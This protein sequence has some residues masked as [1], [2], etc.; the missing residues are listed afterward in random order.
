MWSS[1]ELQ[2]NIVQKLLNK[3]EKHPLPTTPYL[4]SNYHAAQSLLYAYASLFDASQAD[5]FAQG[6][7]EA[8][9][10]FM[11]VNS[12][13][14][15]AEVAMAGKYLGA[16]WLLQHLVNIEI[17]DPEDAE[18][19]SDLDDMIEASL[20]QNSQHKNYDTL[21]GLVSKGIYYLERLPHADSARTQLEQIV[22]SLDQT[23]IKENGFTYWQDH[24]TIDEEY[25][26]HVRYNLGLAHG[27]PGI[28]S[29]LAK[30]F[31]NE[32]LP[33]VSK[34]LLEQS[35]T[36]LV[37]QEL[38]DQ[39]ECFPL[40]I[41][42]GAANE[43]Q[44]RLAWCYGDLCIVVALMH[45]SKALDQ[46]QWKQKAIAIALQTTQKATPQEAGVH[47]SPQDNLMDAGFCHGGGGIAHMYRKLYQATQEEAFQQAAD[48]WLN[49]L[50]T[51]YQENEAQEHYKRMKVN[52]DTK[53]PYWVE[54]YSF[55]EGYA[56]I[57]M[58][59]LGFLDNENNTDWERAFLLDIA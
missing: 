13:I 33:E 18:M 36:W 7:V 59:M 55:L 22:T 58:V 45:A 37:Q 50:V 47:L 42:E 41:I 39:P 2:K 1:P 48:H 29:F 14:A 26:H 27:I 4:F 12:E 6:A 30:A 5:K 32:I 35:V 21:Y 24:F 8:L 25:Q 53:E 16:A 31:Q 20:V 23:A 10:E 17:L 51:Q 52:P 43:R 9:E 34:T 15:H 46:D 28:I 56:G 44:G 54:D 57:A 19:L 11:Q 40:T 38:E 3:F 49:L